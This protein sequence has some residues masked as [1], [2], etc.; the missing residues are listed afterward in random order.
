MSRLHNIKEM[1]RGRKTPNEG[2]RNSEHIAKMSSLVHY[3]VWQKALDQAPWNQSKQDSRVS[4]YS[5]NFRQWFSCE[6]VQAQR[7]SPR[8][9]QLQ[10]K[11]TRGAVLPANASGRIIGKLL[12]KDAFALVKEMKEMEAF[13]ID[14]NAEN[15]HGQVCAIAGTDIMLL[16]E[17]GLVNQPEENWEVVSYGCFVELI[18]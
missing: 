5:F 16:E 2:H 6:C 13:D 14:R 7:S 1:I 18:H 11:L 10:Q 12:A 8:V 4:I 9:E 3:L 17:D 15:T